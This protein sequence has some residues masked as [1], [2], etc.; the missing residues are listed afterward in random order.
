MKAPG[1]GKIAKGVTAA[2]LA[3]TVALLASGLPGQEGPAALE[4]DKFNRNGGA[5]AVTAAAARPGEEVP[6][7]VVPLGQVF[8]IRMFTDGVIVAALSEVPTGDGPVCPAREAGLRPGDFLLAANGETLTDNAHA[9]RVIAG[10]MGRPVEFTVRRREETFA[11]TVRPVASGGSFLTGMWIRDSAAGIGTLTFYDPASGKFAGLGHGIV[12]AD[13]QTLLSLKEGEPAAIELAGIDPGRAGT[14]GT[15]KGYFAGDDP[16]GTLS[17]NRETGVY[18][19]LANPPGG[20]ALRVLEREEVHPGAAQ[21]WVTLDDAGPRAYEVEIE[22][23]G[24]P[25]QATRNLVLRVTDPDLLERT[26]GIV[27]GMSGSPILQDGGLAGAVTH[28]F[29]DDP[30]RGYGIFAKTMCEELAGA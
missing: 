23:V 25:G 16:L 27:Q 22:K 13:A 2:L 1:N 15:L 12:D 18:G 7:Q 26:G 28:V 29:T 24:A 17:A 19:T 5:P 6:R 21:I 30:T 11:A 8:G 9:A 20:E 14:P 4:A 3:V 10:G